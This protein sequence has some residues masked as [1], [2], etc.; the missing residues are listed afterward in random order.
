MM[1]INKQLRDAILDYEEE[2]AEAIAQ[3][4]LENGI[5]PIEMI[6]DSIRPA[7][8]HIGNRFS[9]GDVFLPELMLAAQAADAVVSVLEPAL[10][11]K[12]SAREKVG[13]VLMAT[14]K[15]DIHDIGKNIVSLLLKAAGYEVVDIGV[16]KESDEILKA[17]K[18]HEVDVIGLSALLTT[19]IFKMKDFLEL[20]E[21]DGS[22]EM[23]KVIVGGALVTEDFCQAIGADGYGSDATHAVR[24][25]KKLLEK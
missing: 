23:F 3:K 11:K 7:M 12:G 10:V 1:D 22:R 15:N 19:T 6:N 21:E 13:R 16:D 4:G 5:D 20:L 8:E 14:V 9:S 25:V 24:L 17:A 2:K 18:E